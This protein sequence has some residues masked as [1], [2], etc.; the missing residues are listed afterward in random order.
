M[1]TSVSRR[2]GGVHTSVKIIMDPT[3][4]HATP[5]TR[6]G[7]ITKHATVS[8]FRILQQFLATPSAHWNK[9]SL[10]RFAD[11]LDLPEMCI[12]ES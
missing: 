9:N 4:V 10:L 2:T 8:D 6:W 5:A 11:L 7:W 1:W 12:V 3:T